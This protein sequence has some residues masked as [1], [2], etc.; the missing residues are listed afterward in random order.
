MKSKILHIISCTTSN[1][2]KTDFIF[3]SMLALDIE[4]LG[5]LDQS[6]LPEITCACLFDGSREYCLQF[7]ALPPEVRDQNIA[8]L[9]NLLDAADS[10]VG[11]NAVL[12]DLEFIKRAFGITPQRMGAW[13]RKT[14]DPYMYLKYCLNS[15]SSLSNLL[16]INKLPSKTGSGLEAISMALEVPPISFSF[17][18]SSPS[19]SPS[20]REKWKICCT[21]A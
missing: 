19:H 21:T 7:F 16:A 1:R 4:T 5:L 8:Q 10:L 6:P 2:K 20:H 15:T 13:V 14:I 18:S 11:Y 17:L 3:L 12:F 9:L